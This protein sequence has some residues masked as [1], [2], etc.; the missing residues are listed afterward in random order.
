MIAFDAD[1]LLELLRGNSAVV[2]RAARI[3]TDEQALPIVVVEEIL[4]ARL[5]GI[6]QA[7][8]GR[9]RI[10]LPRAYELFERSLAELRYFLV[11]PFTPEAESLF[12][13]FRNRKVRVP[14]RD[15]RIASICIAHRIKLATRNRRDFDLVPGLD[16]EYWT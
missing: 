8:A 2:E 11:L 7:E 10:T 9:I 4:R 14:T 6:R 16:V 3:A 5:N 1:V 15:L 12:L 13:D